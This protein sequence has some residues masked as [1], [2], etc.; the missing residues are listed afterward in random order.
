VSLPAP[1]RVR[2]VCLDWGGV[3]LRICRSWE[4]GCRAAGLP[5]RAGS[6]DPA[7]RRR[8]HELAQAYQVGRL[9]CG[10]F[11]ESV[12]AAAP[13][14]T[15]ADV[16]RIHDAW[17][18]GEYAGSLALA[19][20]L[21]D[22]PTL[23]SALLSNTNA[24]H[25]RR[26]RDFPAAAALEHQLASHELGL[27]KPE[28]GCFAALERAVGVAGEAIAFF[29]DLEEN[30]A[31]ARAAGWQA[32]RIDHAADPPA[33]IRRALAQLLAPPTGGGEGRDGGSDDGGDQI[34]TGMTT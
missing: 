11:F 33:Q 21:A 23:T 26:R 16:E 30:V 7:L 20:E 12:A 29:D 31:A 8:R 13:G 25:W 17:L 1:E 19:S 14:Y 15:P 28:A 6:G 3:L 5:V 24:A 18:L 9:S 4:E 2:V 22:H 10:A 34:V 32:V 27:A